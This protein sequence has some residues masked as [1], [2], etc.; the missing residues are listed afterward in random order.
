MTRVTTTYQPPQKPIWWTSR[1]ICLVHF[2]CPDSTRSSA[3][4]SIV[5]AGQIL[6]D[7]LPER[8]VSA[9]VSATSPR[10]TST[11]RTVKQLDLVI[12]NHWAAVMVLDLAQANKIRIPA[13]GYGL[14]MNLLPSQNGRVSWI[15]VTV[16][17]TS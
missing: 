8:D 3:Q 16:N 11:I 1:T 5:S 6:A 4:A 13:Q 17:G 15:Q 2:G 9:D 12:A 14:T 10:H 7:L